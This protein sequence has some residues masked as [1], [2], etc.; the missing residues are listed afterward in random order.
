MTYQE[1]QD[2][3]KKIAILIGDELGKKEATEEETMILFTKLIM[4][5]TKTI[6]SILDCDESDEIEED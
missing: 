2:T 4:G 1:S 6:D 5:M 3:Y